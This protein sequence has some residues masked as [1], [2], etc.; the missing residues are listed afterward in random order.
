MM[1]FLLLTLRTQ[2]AIIQRDTKQ[3]TERI[4]MAKEIIL[5]D[6]QGCAWLQFTTRNKC[7]NET[8]ISYMGRVGYQSLA[9][10]CK[11]KGI[12][13]ETVRAREQARDGSWHDIPRN[14]LHMA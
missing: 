10:F 14:E 13:L 8:K 12:G 9:G 1:S 4:S 2:S 11:D 6:K 7:G 3:L 5:L